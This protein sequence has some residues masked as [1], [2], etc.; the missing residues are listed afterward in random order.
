MYRSVIAALD[1]PAAGL[2]VTVHAVERA[3]GQLDIPLV[4]RPGIGSPPIARGAPRPGLP[5]DLA[6]NARRR[7]EASLHFCRNR[8]T[9]NTKSH[10]SWT[11]VPACLRPGGPK[12][13]HL[14][15]SR[16]VRI[17]QLR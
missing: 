7:D 8:R 17:Q 12:R 13:P 1:E 16:P 10:K 4:A 5:V 6:A 2:V 11:G 9:K 15:C 14:K 3:V